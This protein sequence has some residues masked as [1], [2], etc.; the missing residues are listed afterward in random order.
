[1]TTPPLPQDVID[2]IVGG[3][4]IEAI[5]RLRE[6][7]RIDLKTAHDAVEAWAEGRPL[8]PL[9]GLSVSSSAL[10]Q[11]AASL[12]PDDVLDAL[13]GG[14]RIEAI[15]RLREATGLGLKEAKD[16]IEACETGATGG[17]AAPMPT[18]VSGRGAGSGRLPGALLAL[19]VLVALAAWW[20]FGR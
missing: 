11:T 9:P 18:V 17:A 15:K 13:R 7:A 6:A 10:S 1:M 19:V 4:R 14:Q 5:R 12:L 2:A 3:N 16:L 20:W 8:P